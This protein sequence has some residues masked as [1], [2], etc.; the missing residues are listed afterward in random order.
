MKTK[1]QFDTIPVINQK[2]INGTINFDHFHISFNPSSSN[3]GCITTALVL[4]NHIFLILNGN[5][6]DDLVDAAQSGIHGALKYFIQ[7]ISEANNL[8]EHTI[9]SSNTTDKF[10]ICDSIRSVFN[11]IVGM[12]FLTYSNSI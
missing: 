12:D 4:E 2:A 9:L 11:R 8:S 3:Y 7:H 6:V 5:H 1:L 10:G